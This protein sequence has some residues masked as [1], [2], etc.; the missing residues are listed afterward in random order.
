MD[1]GTAYLISAYFLGIASAGAYVN[2]HLKSTAAAKRLRQVGKQDQVY[3]VED[4]RTFQDK[5]EQAKVL[6]GKRNCLISGTLIREDFCDSEKNEKDQRK[7]LY[8]QLKKANEVR[9][10]LITAETT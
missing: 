6:N 4:L 2:F 5:G 1:Q 9:K 3:T 10:K 7:K 8:K